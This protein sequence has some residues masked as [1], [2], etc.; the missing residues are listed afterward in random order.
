MQI[1]LGDVGHGLTSTALWGEAG[2]GESLNLLTY[3]NEW[4]DQTQVKC[5]KTI[6]KKYGFLTQ[7]QFELFHIV[8]NP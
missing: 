7:I 5:L 1:I 4:N 3:V 2:E 6:A 8:Y